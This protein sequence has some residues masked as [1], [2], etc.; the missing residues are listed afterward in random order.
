M[1]LH[2]L[3]ERLRIEELKNIL[4]QSNVSTS[5]KFRVFEAYQIENSTEEL[6]KHIEMR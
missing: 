1:I 2:S 5:E 6:L 3:T 4:I